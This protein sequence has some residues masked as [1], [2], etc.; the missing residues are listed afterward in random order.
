MIKYHPIFVGWLIKEKKILLLDDKLCIYTER[1]ATAYRKEYDDVE[2]KTD[3]HGFRRI[4]YSDIL[5]KSDFTIINGY[6]GNLNSISSRGFDIYYNYGYEKYC[7]TSQIED[8]LNKC[9]DVISEITLPVGYP[10]LKGQAIDYY[11]KWLEYKNLFL[12][13]NDYDFNSFSKYNYERSPMTFEAFLPSAKENIEKHGVFA[14]LPIYKEIEWSFE[15]VEKFKDRVIWKYL[16][17]ESNLIWDENQLNR[18][19]DYI[20]YCVEG[21][22]TYCEKFC[23]DIVLDDYSKLGFLSN[24]FL[25][26]HKDK[27]QW[28]HI[29]DNC[30]IKWNTEEMMYFYQYAISDT[31][32]YSEAFIDSTIRP[33]ME[34][35]FAQ[36]VNN[37]NFYWTSETLYKW[38]SINESHWNI[39]IEKYRPNLFKLFMSIPDIKEL[40]KPHIKN[41]KNFWKIV[42]ND[43]DF[44]YDELSPEF[45]IDNIKR[46]IEIWSLPIRNEYITM[47]RTPDT[48][49]YDYRIETQWDIYQKRINISLSYELA[50]Y[51]MGQNIKLGGSFTKT[52]CGDIE[53]EKEGYS[54]NALMAFSEHHIDSYE[55]ILKCLENSKITDIL[56]GSGF[57][58][59]KDLIKV[60]IS[61]FFQ[62]Y[63]IQDYVDII[64]MLSNWNEIIDFYDEAD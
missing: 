45:T 27:L 26:S 1:A 20:P 3:E 24:D 48:N 23:S 17:E 58:A 7:L 5:S 10:R 64:N 51:L 32:P 55:D 33:S 63:N 11:I 41:I 61:L 36:I 57:G 21:Q 2:I 22:K 6:Y 38:L 37:S 59:N 9:Y 52:D 49:Y 35:Y 43:K 30:C 15:M 19:D 31:M 16:L 62:N 39:F 18:F 46:N 12:K 25:D 8:I 40:A 28:K 53:N 50:D 29:F 42:S 34:Y 60:I 56:L 13:K 14:Y 47:R 44:P 54:G 4:K